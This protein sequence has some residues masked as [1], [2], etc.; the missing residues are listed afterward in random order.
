MSLDNKLRSGLARSAAAVEFESAPSMADVLARGRRR[1]RELRTR[2]VAVAVSGALSAIAVCGSLLAQLPRQGDDKSATTSPPGPAYLALAGTYQ[3]T[4]ESD[5]PLIRARE[6]VGTWTLSLTSRGRLELSPPKGFNRP[7]RQ[8]LFTLDGP[9]LRTNQTVGGL[10]TGRDGV[11]RYGLS[12]GRLRLVKITDN[13]PARA[14]LLGIR[15][16]QRM[17]PAPAGTNSTG[18]LPYLPDDGSVLPPGRYQSEL[19]PRLQIDPPP[20]WTGNADTS[21]WV[22]IRHGSGDTSLSIFRIE[23]LADPR[24]GQPITVPSDLVAWFVAH[25]ALRVVK[26]P[27]PTTVGGRPATRLDVVLAPHWRCPGGD[28]AFAPLQAGEPAFGWASASA[29]RLRARLYVI[30]LAGAWL[31]V[32]ISADRGNFSAATHAAETALL[33]FTWA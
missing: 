2:N 20:G 33:T 11:Y 17:P 30:H 27:R 4:V 28:C 10:C 19:Q 12:G 13:C 7:T 31:V 23:A 22:D 6:M 21:D 18:G 9:R 8:A 15:Q 14:A 3:A 25:P 26:P 29:P 32:E 16:W 24:N 1:R 5:T